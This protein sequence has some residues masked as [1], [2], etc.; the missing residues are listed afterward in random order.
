VSGP[1]FGLSNKNQPCCYSRWEDGV[2]QYI[3]QGPGSEELEECGYEQRRL[4]EG[5]EEVQG[6]HRTVGPVMMMINVATQPSRL[7]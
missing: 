4:A 1:G 6:P 2:I 5:S 7:M 3:R